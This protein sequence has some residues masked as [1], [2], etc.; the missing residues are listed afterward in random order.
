ML[1]SQPLRKNCVSYLEYVIFLY[2]FSRCYTYRVLLPTTINISINYKDCCASY[3]WVREQWKTSM[4]WDGDR[5]SWRCSTMT[6]RS[7]DSK[8]IDPVNW[9]WISWTQLLSRWSQCAASVS[10]SEPSQREWTNPDERTMNQR[11]ANIDKR[12]KLRDW[13]LDSASW[14][15][16]LVK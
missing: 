11:V 4:S 13:V 16:H 10:A 8:D 15:P 7:H 2:S 9:W 5:N 6:T 3:T 12:R 14:R 1:I